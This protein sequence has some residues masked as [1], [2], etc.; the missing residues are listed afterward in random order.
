MNLYYL[1]GDNGMGDKPSVGRIVHYV[2][3]GTPGGEYAPK[4]RAAI[5]TEV[6]AWVT[7]GNDSD[8]SAAGVK[9]A[10]RM[11]EWDPDAVTLFVANP[12]GLFLNPDKPC[13]YDEGGTSTTPG[14]PAGRSYESGTWHWPERVG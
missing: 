8:G 4:C 12:G 5:V 13:R 7:V 3:F 6:G 9:G 2:S 11:Q 14:A 10:Q 1:I